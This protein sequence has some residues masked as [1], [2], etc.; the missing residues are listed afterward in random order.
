[1]GAV[2]EGLPSNLNFVEWMGETAFLVVVG[3]ED[4]VNESSQPP[5]PSYIY[6]N[7]LEVKQ[8]G[9]QQCLKKQAKKFEALQIRYN[10]NGE[11]EDE[12]ED[13]WYMC[14]F[15]KFKRGQG[16]SSRLF[17][18]SSRSFSKKTTSKKY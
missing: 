13:F 8:Q 5:S 18:R 4:V 3:A 16:R 1:M 17:L 11:E 15:Q 7:T 9:Q 12:D 10:N 6:I 2:I 14:S